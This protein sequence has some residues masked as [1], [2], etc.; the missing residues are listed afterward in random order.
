MPVGMFGFQHNGAMIMPNSRSIIRPAIAFLILAVL[1]LSG[2]YGLIPIEGYSVSNEEEVQTRAGEMGNWTQLPSGAW[3]SQIDTSN[4]HIMYREAER[5]LVIFNRHTSGWN[6]YFDVWSYFETNDTWIR[7]NTHGDIPDARYSNKAFIASNNNTMAYFYGGYRSQ[8]YN[9]Y[10]LDSLSIFNYSNMTWVEVDAPPSLGGRY[11]S[12]ITYDK[13]TESIW[14]F[15]GRDSSRDFHNDLFQYNL[16]DGW[17]ELTPS[18]K[19]AAR[20]RGLMTISTNGTFIYLTLGRYYTQWQQPDRYMNDLW[21][22]NTLN[23]TW[24]EISEEIGIPTQAGALFQYRDGSEDLLLS[25]GYADGGDDIIGYT[26]LIDPMNGDVTVNNISGGMP[27]K[28]IQAWDLSSDGSKAYIFGDEGGRKDIWSLDIS[29]LTASKMPGNL[30]WEGGSA[31]TGYDPEDGGKLMTLKR[32]GGSFWQ[33]SYYSLTTMRWES[34]SVSSTGAPS[35]DDGMANCYNPNTNE[36]YLYG[37]VIIEN[38]GQGN[39]RWTHFDEFWRL[40]CD[41]GEWTKIN[42]NGPPGERGRASLVC[43]PENGLLYLFGGQIPD[44]DTNSLWKYNITGNVWSNYNFQVEPQPRR[45]HSVVFDQEKKGF[46]LFGGRRNGTS[47]AELDDLWFFHS[48]TEI[49]EKLPDSGDKPGI[50]TWAGLSYDTDTKELLLFGDVDNE[51]DDMYLWREEWFGWVNESPANKPG[52]WS[53]HGQVYSPQTQR[54]YA[55]A[56]DGTEVWEYRPILRTRAVRVKILN[57]D[58]SNLIPDT[59]VYKVFPSTGTYTIMTEGIT[60]LPQGDLLGLDINI[61]TS[62]GVLDFDWMVSSGIQNFQ[63]N[64]TWFDLGDPQLIW[65]D[66]EEWEFTIPFD[67]EYEAPNGADFNIL[68]V[69]ITDTGRAERGIRLNAFRVLSDLKVA[70]YRF[71]TPLQEQVTNGD[72]L[73]GRTDLTVSNFSVSFL[74]DTSVYPLEG[75]FSIVM[76]SSEGDVSSWTYEPGQEGSITIPIEGEDNDEFRVWLNLTLQSGQ[77]LQSNDFSFI[78]D[79]DPPTAPEWVKVRADSVLDDKVGYDNDN[80]VY[81]TWGPVVENGSGLKGICYSMDLNLWP[82]EVNLTNEFPEILVRDEGLHTFYVWAMDNTGRAGPVMNASLIEDKHFI[83]FTD[84]SPDPAKQI[85]TTEGEFTFSITIEDELSGV[86]LST[87]QYHQSLPDRSLSEWR[88]IEVQANDIKNVTFSLTLDL[89]PGIKNVIGVRATDLAG[90]DFRESTKFGILYEPGLATPQAH[91]GGPDDGAEIEGK[92]RLEWEGGYIEPDMLSFDVHI[93]D[94]KGNEKTITTSNSFIEFT[95]TYPGEYTWWIVSKAEGMTNESEIRTFVYQAPMISVEQKETSEAV[96][97]SEAAITLI[98]ENPL[99]VGVNFTFDFQNLKG[100]TLEGGNEQSIL[101]GE[102]KEVV[103]ALGT[104]SV[105]P[106]SY[107]LELDT[108]DEYGRTLITDITVKITPQESED[109]EEEEEGEFPIWIIIVIVLVLL[110]VI[111][112]VVFLVVNRGKKEEEIEEEEEEK[113]ISLDYDPTGV[114]AEGG[115]SVPLA[116]GMSISDEEERSRGSNVM[117]ISLP[118]ERTVEE[119]TEE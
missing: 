48:D 33:L 111:V 12:A 118:S 90:N 53:G 16:T 14:I 87:I 13:S 40:D 42:D 92:I 18:E 107:L 11:D 3:P 9:I 10:T 25:M 62:A 34:Q 52:E 39:Y 76:E 78:L 108:T 28:H 83:R 94:P 57:T 89:V 82:E 58:G 4:A 1:I 54:H 46:F 71:S 80:T 27:P 95:P 85:N 112:L 99:T 88:D 103:I 49:W 65:T 67:I 63:G 84:I 6:S 45:E 70:G 7:W 98:V 104:S 44:A 75:D 59:G 115:S 60:D 74:D 56:H 116:P 23:N 109:E 41:T 15:G 77:I 102:Q 47:S 37:G 97:G 64:E 31:F 29:T 24:L 21:F 5:E 66:Q 61:S 35:Y 101:P 19:P 51:D 93:E 50:Q 38:L 69:P 32:V 86:N 2:Y 72:W 119:E 106:D 81:L 55:W 17:N 22:F 117:E 79:L 43:D 36:F 100:F 105:K 73:F 114:V 113:P 68:I 110:V 8:G 20:E 26:Y 91:M 30:A 96:K